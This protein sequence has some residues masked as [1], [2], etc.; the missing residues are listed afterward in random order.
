MDAF[1]CIAL[2]F[3]THGARTLVHNRAS[4]EQSITRPPPSH[5]LL[6]RHLALAYMLR[7]CACRQVGRYLVNGIPSDRAAL[8]IG[9]YP[10]TPVLGAYESANSV[11]RCR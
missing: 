8:F 6:R 9:F 4:S 3:L 10:G 7:R 1:R 2:G 5:S 11:G